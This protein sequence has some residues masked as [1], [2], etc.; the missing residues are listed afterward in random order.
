MAAIGVKLI[1]VV[2]AFG[3]VTSAVIGVS[4]YFAGKN[5]VLWFFFLQSR[6][7]TRNNK[8]SCDYAISIC[9]LSMFMQ[10]LNIWTNNT[11]KTK[12]DENDGL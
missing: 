3:V 9:Q 11:W 5:Y 1:V 6:E 10:V 12:V 2:V 7:E 4:A 8:L